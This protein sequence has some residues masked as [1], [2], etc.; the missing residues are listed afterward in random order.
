MKVTRELSLS[1]VAITGQA[2]RSCRK[3]VIATEQ[4]QRY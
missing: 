2:R 3:G 4:G 1:R